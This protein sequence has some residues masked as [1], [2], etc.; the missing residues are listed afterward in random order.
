MSFSQHD[1]QW[2]AEEVTR[3]RDTPMHVAYMLA[4]LDTARDAWYHQILDLELIVNLARDV[5]NDHF[6]SFRTIPVTFRN[7]DKG[8][9]DS[10]IVRA[11]TN[12][13]ESDL[14]PVDFYREFE[15]IHPF[16]DGNGRVGSILYNWKVG[17]LN[18]PTAPPDLFG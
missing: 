7:G 3:Q 9:D 5:N 18:E 1:V 17:T 11:L 16:I 13:V 10:L 4:A 15:W 12:L 8:L 2:A 6:L 14:G